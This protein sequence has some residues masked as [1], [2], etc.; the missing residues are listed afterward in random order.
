MQLINYILERT[1]APS[2][3]AR[4]AR[5]SGNK[6]NLHENELIGNL[7]SV[8]VIVERLTM[9]RTSTWNCSSTRTSPRGVVGAAGKG[10]T[11]RNPVETWDWFPASPPETSSCHVIVIHRH[12]EGKRL[13]PNRPPPGRGPRGFFGT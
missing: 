5:T 6:T 1:H 11:Q 10:N 3:T 8:V 13:H 12:R 7:W 2:P 4:I 9:N